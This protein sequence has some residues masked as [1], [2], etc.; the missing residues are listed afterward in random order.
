MCHEPKNIIQNFCFD[1]VDFPKEPKVGAIILRIIGFAI[2]KII[3]FDS[4]IVKVGDL[5][6]NMRHSG[7]HTQTTI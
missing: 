4:T 3:G 6:M 7:F 1:E 5:V 2:V